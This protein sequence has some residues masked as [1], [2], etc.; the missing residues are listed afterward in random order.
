ML[1]PSH[2]GCSLGPV[3][4]RGADA[5]RSAQGLEPYGPP[6]GRSA[7]GTGVNAAT[8]PYAATE[9]HLPAL[10]HRLEFL[11]RQTSAF[12]LEVRGLRRQGGSEDVCAT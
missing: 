8:D 11:S 4:T 7:S 5:G 12:G 9:H 3:G 1:L 6:K 10:L 2:R